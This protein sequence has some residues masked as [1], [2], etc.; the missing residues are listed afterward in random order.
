[1]LNYIFGRINMSIDILRNIRN[2]PFIFLNYFK[3]IHSD[4]LMFR[5]RK[6]LV[7]NIRNI[8]NKGDTS[9]LGMVWEILI[10]KNYTP[11]GFEIHNT[12]IIIDIGS[13][14]GVFSLYA[15]KLAKEG[16][17]YSYEPFN[18]HYSRLNENIKINNCK[19]IHAFNLAVC[20]KKGKRDLFI[21]NQ[22]SGMHSI[23][24]KKNS[25]EKMSIN[26]TTLKD[27]FKENKIKQCD[28]LKIDCEGAE[29]D[30]LYNSPASILKKVKKIALEFDNIDEKR[31][32]LELKRFLENK[33]FSVRINGEIEKQ[34]ILYAKRIRG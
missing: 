5:F 25:K 20:D 1:M 27:I 11:N 29:Y 15:S 18:T 12:D 33:G 4:Y 6:G 13:N 19:N 22:S 8:K 21:S 9:G 30:I 16:E 2:W 34:G 24:F 31:N 17:I 23:I 32:S 7:L 26:C 14:I 28:L 10:K 3:I